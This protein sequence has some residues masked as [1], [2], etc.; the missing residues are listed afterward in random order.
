MFSVDVNL[1]KRK[2]TPKIVKERRPNRR[3]RAAAP[4]VYQVMKNCSFLF[5]KF[6]CFLN[7]RWN[8]LI[9]ATCANILLSGI[10]K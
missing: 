6:I 8:V 3:V 10:I 2:I 4:Q 1:N 7:L 9:S 5:E